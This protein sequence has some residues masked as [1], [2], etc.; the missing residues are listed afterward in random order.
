MEEEVSAMSRANFVGM[1]VGV[2][3]YVA[4]SEVRVERSYKRMDVCR[5]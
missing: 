4:A 5:D 3:D 1:G 2:G